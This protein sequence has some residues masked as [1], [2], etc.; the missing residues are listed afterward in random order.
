MAARSGILPR[1]GEN[2]LHWSGVSDG[3]VST[4]F[5][6]VLGDCKYVRL[7]CR[8]ISKSKLA[9]PNSVLMCAVFCGGFHKSIE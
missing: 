8:V 5:T 6:E 7:F 3:G 9:I 1:P 4:T 2:A